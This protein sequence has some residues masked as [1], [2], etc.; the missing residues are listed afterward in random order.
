MHGVRVRSKGYNPELPPTDG[1]NYRFWMVPAFGVYNG[2]FY[3]EAQSL[4]LVEAI[5]L[6]V[7]MFQLFLNDHGLMLD[8]SNMAAIEMWV[9]GMW[10][11]LED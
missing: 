3:V 6:V 5:G 1:F 4:E 11:E 10:E 9:D 8:Y 7:P 2:D